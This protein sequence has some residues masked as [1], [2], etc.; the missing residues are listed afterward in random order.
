M[1]IARSILH[2]KEVNHALAW[3]S[4][5]DSRTLEFVHPG[6]TQASTNGDMYVD[7]RAEADEESFER[8]ATADGLGVEPQGILYL[9]LTLTCS[10]TSSWTGSTQLR[11]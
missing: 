9:L 10:L 5:V 11:M 3:S 4:N 2:L 6:S 7:S 1:F 8:D